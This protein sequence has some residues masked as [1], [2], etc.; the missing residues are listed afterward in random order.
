MDETIFAASAIWA[1]VLLAVTIIAL[2]RARAA[3]LRILLADTVTLILVALLLLYAE[4]VDRPY[5]LDAA[6]ALAMLSFV[7]T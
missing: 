5:F 2:V 7:A 4:R 1:T 3:M 6:L